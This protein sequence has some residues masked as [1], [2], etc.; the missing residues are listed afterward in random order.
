MSVC[1]RRSGALFLHIPKTGG[2]WVEYA[3]GQIGIETDL[4][5]TIAGVTFRHSLLSMI[6]RNYPFVFT[7]VRHPLSWYESWWKFQ[8]GI[9][10]IFEPGVWHPQRVLEPCRSDDFNEFVRLVIENEPGYVSRM[11]EWFIGP[12]GHQFVQFVGR[13]ENLVEDLIEVLSCLGYPIDP[14][15][16]RRL[17]RANE[18]E[19]RFGEP[20]WD[21]GLRREVLGL[22]TSA[23]RR[24]YADRP[25]PCSR[26]L[27]EV[28]D[29][30]EKAATEPE[31]GPQVEGILPSE[32]L[33]PAE[34][35]LRNVVVHSGHIE[36]VEGP[37][38]EC[39]HEP[40]RPHADIAPAGRSGAGIARRIGL[41]LLGW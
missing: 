3:L 40:H 18:S 35:P 14:Q 24:F 10:K 9:W 8:A 12:P 41:T 21:P 20:V 1:L 7:F 4:A 34:P 6:T 39:R 38:G 30:L 29:P 26:T 32:T 22:E 5:Q 31:R 13:Q 23:I 36:A 2:S 33:D 17:A 19:K 16:I 37:S 25:E 28:P 27:P 15:A 11:Y